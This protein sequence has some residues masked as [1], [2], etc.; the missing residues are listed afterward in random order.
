M[1]KICKQ[2]RSREKKEKM[3]SKEEEE[4]KKKQEEVLISLYVKALR[5]SEVHLAFH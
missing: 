5:I 1:G 4:I 2:K 3:I